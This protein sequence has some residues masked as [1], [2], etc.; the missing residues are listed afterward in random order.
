MAVD[1]V[2]AQVRLLIQAGQATPAPPV[3]PA[4]GQYGINIMEF[5]K[6]F[7]ERSKGRG[8][9]LIPVVITVYKDNS[10]D[11]IMKSPPT[12]F[13]L[14]KAAGILKGSKEPNREKVATVT[15]KQL[16]EIAKAKLDSF[17]TDDIDKVVKIIEGTARSMGML[18]EEG[19]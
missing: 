13:L 3:G 16:R 11:F 7:N 10:F 2:K 8:D 12:S 19:E 9:D 15:R 14:K 4:L 1:K 5:C 6:Q 17:N 18:I